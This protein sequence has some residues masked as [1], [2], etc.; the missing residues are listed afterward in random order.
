MASSQRRRVLVVTGSRAEFGLLRSVMDAVRGHRGLELLT[1][2]AGSHLLSPARTEREVAAAYRVD[3]R[4]VMQK[5]GPGGRV[6]DSRA[7]AR[8]IAGFADAYEKLRP[9]WV[10]VLGDRIEA[11]A[12]ASCASIAGLAVCHIHGGDR[13][14][15]IADEAMRHAVSKMAHLHCAATEQSAR[16]LIRMGEDP[17][18][19]VVTGSPGIDGL[20]AV[21]PV[22]D[23]MMEELGFPG[24]VVLV[25]PS[26]RGA[27]EDRAAAVAALSVAWGLGTTPLVLMPNADAGREEIVKVYRGVEA[28]GFVRVREHLPRYVF[29]GLLKRLAR[30]GGVLIGNSSAGLIEAAA[31]GLRVVNIGPRQNGR[32]RAGNVVEIGAVNDAAVMRVVRTLERVMGGGKRLKG[33]DRFGDGRAGV[34]IAGLLA[35]VD[36]RGAGFVVKRNAY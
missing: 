20:R 1:C 12:A 28:G 9:D 6:A 35:R 16:R 17:K 21:K 31:I 13:A 18:R 10:V 11:F 23:E 14:E 29:V 34:R 32:E 33:S 4:V 15:G 8:G 3:A 5:A 30:E 19:V 22:D 7:V 36:P 27:S 2:V 25:H 24:S 26:G